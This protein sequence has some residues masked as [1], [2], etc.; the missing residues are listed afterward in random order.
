LLRADFVDLYAKNFKVA[1]LAIAFAAQ[2]AAH[3]G[4][5][6]IEKIR[7][8]LLAFADAFHRGSLVGEES[9]K[10]QLLSAAFYLYSRGAS[11]NRYFQIADL[12][13]EIIRRWPEIA[14]YSK[15]LVDRL[16]RR[17]P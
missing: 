9:V 8:R 1:M 16:S 4:R 14:L 12:L 6:I 5:E 13:S 7:V 3:S 17:N 15:T 2:H 11:A 10:G